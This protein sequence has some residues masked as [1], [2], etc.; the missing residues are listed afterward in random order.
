M[1]RVSTDGA[2]YINLLGPPQVAWRNEPLALTRRQSRAL[3]F[4]LAHTPEPVARDRLA[5]LFWPDL[6][7]PDARR[8]LKRLLSALRHTLP[9]DTLQTTARGAVGLDDTGVF[10][11]LTAFNA[12]SES[13]DP[14]SWGQA[15]DL[16]RGPFLD[17]FT[18]P[19]CPEY[20]EWQLQMQSQTEQR[21]LAALSR[22]LDAH[23]AAGEL[24]A[25]VHY[26]LRYLAADDLA[27]DVH[28]RLIE[29]H[30]A[31][32]ERSAAARQFEQ[33]ALH[34]ERE[35]GVSPLPET[36]AAYE[37]AMATQPVQRP[38][39]PLWAVLPSLTVP[40]IGR[41][42][43]WQALTKAHARL[44]TGGLIL[45]AGEPGVGKSRLMREFAT[46]CQAFVLSGNN[47]VGAETIPYTAIVAALRQ[48]LS[49]PQRWRSIPPIWLAET[50]R[51][52][53]EIGELFPDLPPPVAL[54]Q[55]SAQT[56]LF[57]ALSRCLRALA[58]DGPVLL[59]LDDLQ[60]ADPATLS[61]LAGLPRQ[62]AGSRVCVLATCRTAD[63]ARLAAVRRAFARPGLLAETSLSCLSVEAVATILAHLPQHPPNLSRL[64]ARLHHAT[65]GNPFFVLETLRA[66]LEGDHLADPPEQLPLAPTVQAAIQRRLDRLS[67]LGR[68]ILE[69]AAVLAPD[70]TFDLV[71]TAAGRSD[72]ETAQ[73]LDETA[74]RQLLVPGDPLH[75]NHDL[76]R[77][78]V[79]AAISPWRRRILHRRAAE[80]L[81]AAFMSRS[82]PVWASM[83]RHYE[84]AGDTGETIRCLEQAALAAG[85]LYAHQE[86]IEH[87]ERALELGRTIAA[88]RGA[89]ARLRELLG[90]SLMA[91]G[92]HAQAQ[93]AFSAALALTP[94]VDPLTQAGL[95]RKL[96]AS[97]Q[98]RHLSSEAEAASDRALAALGPPAD[99]WPP[100]WRH[101]PL[102][103][104]LARMDIL[105][106]QADLDRL[107]R[108]IADI[109]P[110]VTMIDSPT[111]R[112]D[113][114]GGLM[115]LAIRREHFTLSA[116][117]V[118]AA[119]TLLAATQATGV[120]ARLAWG[121]FGLGFS[122]LWAGR[123]TEAAMPLLT[124]LQQAR[125]YGLAYTEVLCLTY[126]ACLYRFLDN[127]TEAQRYADGSLVACETVDMPIYRAT[128]HA[129]LAAL[130]RRHG[131]VEAAQAAAQR[132]LALWDDSPYPFRWL[133]HWVLLAVYTARGDLAA[134]ATQ[135]QAILHPSQRRQPGELPQALA[136]AVSAWSE[137]PDEARATLRQA[138][139]LAEIEGYL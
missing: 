111:Y 14:S 136:R 21:Y 106:F 57:D 83:A 7:D 56:R 26:A 59:C 49:S 95:Y 8:N 11:D 15:V 99:D 23:R 86:A 125:E 75:F 16:Y 18:V 58:D 20:G 105:Y 96:S 114:A 112:A 108:L 90:D 60:W 77:Q 82:E 35:L 55:T 79:Y 39:P 135:A 45:I 69:T 44:R 123:A 110:V 63:D 10:C 71:Q 66:L 73:G 131:Q 113:F 92:R 38:A 30:G 4:Y 130:H 133:A 109:E 43:A 98:A 74:G 53:P 84:Q 28:R 121:W 32:G 87:L 5:F 42:E 12:L 48:A 139:E 34:L 13:A 31:R 107:T 70:L 127:A 19:D 132:A 68:Q 118:A 37:A 116:D 78:A 100:A 27:E 91:R 89:T 33:C 17:G 40:L 137:H 22:L 138:M 88:Q 72:L 102:E 61:W 65:G 126:L 85:K 1:T 101:V 62:I 6:P 80:A 104:Q 36:R 115:D 103:L 50:G 52:L 117:T 9:D 94:G 29:L 2:L 120:P 24:D 134:A 51:L 76:V 128:A 119:E 81:D 67:P 47:P 46:A 25:A 3:L 93:E 64:A 97:F 124:G 54:E 122:L 129:N 41:E